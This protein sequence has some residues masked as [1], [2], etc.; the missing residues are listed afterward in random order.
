[1]ARPVTINTKG[2]RDLQKMMKRMETALEPADVK[3][4][5]ANAL[6]LIKHTAL[7]LLNRLVKHS[8]HKK[9]MMGWEH[10]A[11][12]LVVREGKSTRTASAFAKVFR[13]AAP[14]AIWIEY[15]HRIVGH[16]SRTEQVSSTTSGKIK[17]TAKR[18]TGKRAR[19]FPFFRPAIDMNRAAVRKKI[20]DGIEILLMIAERDH[21]GLADIRTEGGKHYSSGAEMGE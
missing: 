18:D 21:T 17:R 5:L 11:E 16:K 13:K 15:G 8:H 7:A 9:F 20:R 10:I 12:A 2:L 4:V 1:M 3:P 14:H 19:A 6:M